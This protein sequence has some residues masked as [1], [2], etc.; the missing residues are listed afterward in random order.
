MS[1]FDNSSAGDI[2]DDVHTADDDDFYFGSGNN[3]D[4]IS[5]VS[6]EA[7]EINQHE[8]NTEKVR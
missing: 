2:N 8:I 7:Q 6:M 4:A 5:M 1:G 3:Q